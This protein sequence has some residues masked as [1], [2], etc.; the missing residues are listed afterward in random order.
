[1]VS[2]EL[3]SLDSQKN[4]GGHPPA[5]GGPSI[6]G[7]RLL[8]SMRSDGFQMAPCGWDG[9]PDK[10]LNEWHLTSVRDIKKSVISKEKA[11]KCRG[12]FPGFFY[13]GVNS[14]VFQPIPLITCGE[15]GTV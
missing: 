3:F 5:L 14:N 15:I 6:R 8:Y 9:A 7:Y 13:F 1:M 11:S 12:R 10:A 2:R 4:A